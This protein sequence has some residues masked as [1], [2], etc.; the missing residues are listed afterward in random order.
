MPLVCWKDAGRLQQRQISSLRQNQELIFDV[1]LFFHVLY[2]YTV[3]Y[4][5]VW[6]NNTLGLSLSTTHAT[7]VL[8]LSFSLLGRSFSHT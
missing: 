1:I 5:V 7:A 4:G 3:Y 8:L 6:R 2:E